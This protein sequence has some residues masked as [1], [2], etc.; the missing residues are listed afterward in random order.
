MIS[1]TLSDNE[2]RTFV[3]ICVCDHD[4]CYQTLRSILTKF[5]THFFGCIILVAFVNG[6]NYLS[7]FEIMVILNIQITL[8][9]ECPIILLTNHTNNKRCKLQEFN[10][11]V[12]YIP[13][14]KMAANQRIVLL[15][16]E[17]I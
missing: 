10:I 7:R 11:L 17:I 16:D 1:S 13:H 12:L 5:R 4:S 3:C 9:L 14:N 15:I 2:A 6:E 8:F